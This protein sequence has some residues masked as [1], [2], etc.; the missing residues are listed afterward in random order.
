MNLFGFIIS[1]QDLWLLVIAGVLIVILINYRLANTGKKIARLA[2][3]STKFRELFYSELNGLYPIPTNWPA[4]TNMLD[5]RLRTAFDKFQVAIDE[6]GRFLPWY[7]R[8]LLL[9]L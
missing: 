7:Q 9:P 1:P 5:S 8:L 6:F 3:A 2:T 4:D